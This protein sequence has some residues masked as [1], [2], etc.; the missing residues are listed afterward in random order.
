MKLVLVRHGATEWS[1]SGRHTGNTDV[2]LIDAGRQQALAAQSR[3]LG[4]IEPATK[5]RICSSPLRR[6][7]ETVALIMGTEAEVEI[8]D[9]LREFDYGDYEGLTTPE[10]REI[11]P[12]WTVF[13][14][15]PG[16][17][18]LND[19]E[20][21]VDAFLKHA[22]ADTTVSTTVIFAHGHLLRILG[23]RAIGQPGEFAIHLGLDTA[24]V[25]VI[26]DLRDGPAITLWNDIRY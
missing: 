22:R 3:V 4:N 13:D 8:D 19:V 10:I 11:D 18:S 20:A 24:A 12:R 6:A 23:A 5:V 16:G 21:R 25:C 1:V 9:R 2:S 15:C 26:A 17:E 14:G 7:L